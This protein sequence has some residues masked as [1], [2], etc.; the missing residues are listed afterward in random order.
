MP[1]WQDQRNLDF[2]SDVMSKKK[3]LAVF[4]CCI[5]KAIPVQ[6]SRGLQGSRRLRLTDF[7]TISMWRW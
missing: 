2:T 1:S 3:T 4:Q 7:K 5:C 6:A